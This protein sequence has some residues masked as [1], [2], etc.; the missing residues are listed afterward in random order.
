LVVS[1]GSLWFWDDQVKGPQE[2]YRVL[3]PGGVAFVGG[4]LG[5]YTPPGMRDRLKGKRRAMIKKHGDARF[6]KG[7]Q[8]RQ[9]LDETGLGGCRLVS[10][11]E[12]EPAT[13]VEMLKPDSGT[14]SQ[15]GHR[16]FA[17]GCRVCG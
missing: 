6:L 9:L 8:L 5:R 4:G 12:G 7:D 10:D 16:R 2:I 13:W 3:K 17:A 14:R 11:A 15:Q 1:R